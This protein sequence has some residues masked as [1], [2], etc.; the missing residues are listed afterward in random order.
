MA[1]GIP[2]YAIS[3]R[4]IYMNLDLYGNVLSQLTTKIGLT[5]R[6]E[7]KMSPKHDNK[8][9]SL[10]AELHCGTGCGANQCSP[11]PT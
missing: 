5:G 8:H 9:Q 10:M 4:R 3:Q 7:L 11:T 1:Y 6:M 2:H